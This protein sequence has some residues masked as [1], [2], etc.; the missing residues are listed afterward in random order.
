[1]E[2]LRNSGREV[3]ALAVLFVRAAFGMQPYFS[4]GCIGSYTEAIYFG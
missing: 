4:K 3:E 2:H 1:M